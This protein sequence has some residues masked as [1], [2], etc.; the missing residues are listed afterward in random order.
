MSG[1]THKLY[2]DESGT[3]EY[4]PDLSYPAA[5]GRTRFFVFAGILITPGAAGTAAAELLALKMSCFGRP[6]VE[7][8]AN[9]LKRPI[10]RKARYLDPFGLSDA[11]LNEFVRLLYE[12]LVEL[13]AEFIAA[14]VDKRAVQQQYAHGPWYPPAIAYEIMMQ[15]VQIAMT[16]AGGSVSVTVDDMTGA[17]PAGN[18][19][20]DNLVKHHRGLKASGSALAP[21][22]RKPMDRLA[23]LSFSNSKH[24]ERLQL[25][26]LVAYC[27]YR[28]FVDHAA[29][30][31][32]GGQQLAT[33]PY[34][35]SIADRF[36]KS[37]SGVISG[38]GVVKFPR[39]S[40]A[41]WIVTKKN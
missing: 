30:W 15:R 12:L 3:K 9:W 11:D 7:I 41:R 2:V 18:Q 37:P 36:R 10:E 8:K 35:L 27:C 1:P 31:D 33:Y 6:D 20:K 32:A 16:E 21:P 19:Y 34:F 17:T 25:A 14:I 22:P 4:S 13:P 38:F 26:D 29:D 40:N 28:Q 24:D 23:D 39:T 5:G